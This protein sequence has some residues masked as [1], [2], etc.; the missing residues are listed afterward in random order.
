[1]CKIRR[2]FIVTLFVLTFISLSSASANAQLL[3]PSYLYL[4]V[5]DSNGK[6]VAGATVNN[7]TVQTDEQGQA[8]LSRDRD[9]RKPF[10]PEFTIAK[11]GYF[12]FQDL[13]VL[14]RYSRSRNAKIELLKIPQTKAERK[15]LGDEQLKREF[16]SAIQNADVQTVGK[17]L[18]S[19]ISPNITINDLRGFPKREQINDF[20][21]VPAIV[22][23][24]SSGSGETVKTLLGAGA[25]VRKPNPYIDSIL[26]FYLRADPFEKRKSETE[27]EKTKAMSEY[28]DG[29]K[30]LIKAGANVNAGDHE[31]GASA[32]GT[33]LIIAV[34]KGYTGTVKIL[35]DSGAKLSASSFEQTTPLIV[36]A[37]GKNLEIAQLLIEKGVSLDARD[38]DGR[39]AL[40]HAVLSNPETQIKMADLLIKSGADLNI[41]NEKS[42]YYILQNCQTALM[43][44]VV[45]NNL[46]MTKFLIA[47]K[48]SVNLA[49]PNGD[50]ALKYAKQERGYGLKN[51]ELIELLEAAGAK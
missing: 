16:F 32:D 44:A 2:I 38:A 1:M 27:A 40:M 11:S 19:G 28:E 43:F 12:P 48:A 49:C 13:G 25:D 46:E 45:N 9:G 29:L 37:Q 36:A 30:A 20:D 7:S 17:L 10:A 24:A 15:A 21:V 47:H 31:L 18:K 22:Y 26:F 6:P 4:E 41:I 35:I 3:P 8:K 39:T 23:A 50:T 5:L 34:G 42:W 33:P 51:Q 14:E